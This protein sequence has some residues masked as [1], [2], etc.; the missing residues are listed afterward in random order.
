[1]FLYPYKSGNLPDFISLLAYNR[2]KPTDFVLLYPYKN[3]NLSDFIDLYPYKRIKT[4]DL[5][6]HKHYIQT[7]KLHIFKTQS[8]HLPD[9]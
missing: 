5:E 7:P 4:Q 2:V 3:A 6:R 8:K 1:M 9:F